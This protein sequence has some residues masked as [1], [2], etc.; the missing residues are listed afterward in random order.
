[1]QLFDV[2]LNSLF[3]WHGDIYKLISHDD[4]NHAVAVCKARLAEGE[5]YP[6]TASAEHFNPYT[7]VEPGELTLTWKPTPHP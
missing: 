3:R 6:V 2:P 5:L 1:M 4:P 7:D